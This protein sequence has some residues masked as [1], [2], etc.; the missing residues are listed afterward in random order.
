[1]YSDDALIKEYIAVFV[2]SCVGTDFFDSHDLSYIASFI[3]R[4]V[5]DLLRCRSTWL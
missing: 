2:L 5:F 4:R 1:M 3:L